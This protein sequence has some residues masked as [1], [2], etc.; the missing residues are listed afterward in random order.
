MML[1]CHFYVLAS[2]KSL[3]NV[4]TDEKNYNLIFQEKKEMFGQPVVGQTL[5]P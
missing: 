5:K 1:L 2:S 4:T 3:R